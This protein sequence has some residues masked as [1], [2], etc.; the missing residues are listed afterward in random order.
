MQSLKLTRRQ[1]EHCTSL[2]VLA[3]DPSG[4]EVLLGLDPVESQ[5]V[6]ECGN[7]NPGARTGPENRRLA[8]LV[9][10]HE[11]ARLRSMAPADGSGRNEASLG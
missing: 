6:V 5:F 9:K 4:H 7:M 2:G 10:R 1:R 3:I 8:R 11:Q